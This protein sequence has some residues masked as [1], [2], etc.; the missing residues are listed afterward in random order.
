V[1]ESVK[2]FYGNIEL[3]QLDELMLM[4]IN[5]LELAGGN[6][7]DI[8]IWKMDLKWAFALLNF[9]TDEIGL[10]TMNLTE[11]LSCQQVYCHFLYCWC[12]CACHKWNIFGETV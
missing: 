6:W 11:N 8:A 10:L 1:R 12:G 2:Q 4:I 7:E 9:K 5:Q 3:A